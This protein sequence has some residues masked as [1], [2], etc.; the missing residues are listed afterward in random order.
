MLSFA[1]FCILAVS[2]CLPLKTPLI[3]YNRELANS[4]SFWNNIWSWAPWALPLAG[5]LF[6]LLLIFPFG[7]CIINALSRFISQQPTDQIPALSQGIL[8]S[9][10]A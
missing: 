6:M 7:P 10:Y 8:T 1:L 3:P 2:L 9:A 5:P 4:W